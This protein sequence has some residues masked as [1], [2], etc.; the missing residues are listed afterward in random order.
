MG[1]LRALHFAAER[2]YNLVVKVGECQSL[3]QKQV[4]NANLEV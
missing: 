4:L 2:V 3:K 1:G